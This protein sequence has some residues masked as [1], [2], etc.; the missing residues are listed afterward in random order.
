MGWKNFTE[1]EE[2]AAGKVEYASHV[3]GFFILRVLY[4]VKPYIRG[5]Q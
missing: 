5:K 1:T 3:D 4:I 2:G